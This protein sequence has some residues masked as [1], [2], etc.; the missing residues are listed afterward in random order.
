M[1]GSGGLTEDIVYMGRGDRAG[2]ETIVTNPPAMGRG[3]R[4]LAVRG[5]ELTAGAR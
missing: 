5:A 4:W 3:C 2:E 1:G